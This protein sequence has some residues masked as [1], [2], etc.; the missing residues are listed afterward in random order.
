MSFFADFRKFAFRGNVL[1][2]AVGVVIGGAFGR[3]VTATVEDAVM[4]VVSLVMPGGNW[5]NRGIVLR[6]AQDASENVTLGYGHL[7]G[8]TLDFFIIALV[9]FVIVSR[10]MRAAEARLL[11]ASEAP[12]GPTPRCPSCK[13]TIQAGATR[14]PHCTSSLSQKLP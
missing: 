13:E 6:H 7:L 4:P 8:A 11:G 14:C 12:G 2:L 3:V 5:R 10:V 1:D 9:L